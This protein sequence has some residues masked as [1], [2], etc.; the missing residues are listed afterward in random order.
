[1]IVSYLNYFLNI[2]ALLNIELYHYVDNKD[3]KFQNETIIK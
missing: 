1:M 2:I 3:K